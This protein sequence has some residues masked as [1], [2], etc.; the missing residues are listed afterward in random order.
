[1]VCHPG[2]LDRELWWS[3]EPIS[4]RDGAPFCLNDY[5]SRNRFRDIMGSI[6]YTKRPQ[7]T[8]LDKFHDISEMQDAWNEHM[9]NNYSPGWWNCLD[10]SMNI[11]LNKYCP[12]YMIVP[13]KLH[14][15]GNEYHTICD[16]NLEKGNPI[17]LHVELMEGKDTPADA[18]PKKYS[19]LGKTPGLM[20]RIFT[21][22]GQLMI[23]QSD[24]GSKFHGAAM[25][26]RYGLITVFHFYVSL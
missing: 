21:I 23:L 14:E 11:Y 6:R 5:I 3:K 15:E 24:N 13:R 20:C 26:A 18:P 22:I 12:G 19:D 9:L 17:M 25:N 2:V 10:E 4:P 1:M 7:P 8:Y 16:G